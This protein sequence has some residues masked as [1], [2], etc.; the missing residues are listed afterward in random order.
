MPKV[1]ISSKKNVPGYFTG[2]IEGTELLIISKMALNGLLVRNR[3]LATIVS[4][5]CSVWGSV[6]DATFMWEE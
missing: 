6:L 4:G 5:A 3:R 2:P 1:A